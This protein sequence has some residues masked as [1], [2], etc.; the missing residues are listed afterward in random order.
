MRQ[1]CLCPHLCPSL[2]PQSLSLSLSL[3]SLSFFYSSQV[4]HFISQMKA[5]LCAACFLLFC[6][7]QTRCFRQT[8]GVPEHVLT[9]Q[10]F[11]WVTEYIYSNN[12]PPPPPQFPVLCLF[13]LL[14]KTGSETVPRREKEILMT[15]LLNGRPPWSQPRLILRPCSHIV[16]LNKTNP[17]RLH[18]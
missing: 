1:C 12:P 13:L 8:S 10:T 11:V 17:S 3:L 18:L 7:F 15:L 5:S 9:T 2:S 6:F 14:P 16:S 4:W